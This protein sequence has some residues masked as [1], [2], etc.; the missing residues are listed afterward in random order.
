[1]VDSSY[2]SFQSWPL[3]IYFIIFI[4][5]TPI[6]FFIFISLL[7]FRM[8]NSVFRT[9][10]YTLLMQ[11]II[12]DLL[13]LTFYTIFKITTSLFSEYFF[14]Q[15]AIPFAQISMNGVYWCIVFRA[16]GIALLTIHRYL[17]IVKPSS[18]LTHFIQREKQLLICIRF[19]IPPIIFNCFFF[20]EWKIRFQLASILIFAMDTSIVDINKSRASSGSTDS[21]PF[22]G[23]LAL[24]LYMTFLN[25]YAS[26]D[27]SIMIQWIRGFF[28]LVNGVISFIGP[29]TIL[30][31]N[32]ELT[33]K[34]RELVFHNKKKT[35][36][37]STLQ[38]ARNNDNVSMM[39]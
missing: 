13:S 12:S 23:L 20:L 7:K 19:W 21:L 15:E 27:N 39:S 9:S 11:H 10:F 24:L 38:P 31:F 32:K 5:I 2:P 18:V 37:D 1:M 16:H 8:S 3:V 29:F 33:Q 34:V 25:M 6:Y 28:P 30:L 26:N 22:A 36:P 17:V 14:F 4:F 35:R